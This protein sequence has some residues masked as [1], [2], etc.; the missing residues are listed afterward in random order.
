MTSPITKLPLIVLMLCGSTAW[1][2]MVSGNI[3]TTDGSE[4]DVQGA[5]DSARNGAI[6]KIQ[7]GSYTWN[8]PV[9]NSKNTAVHIMAQSLGGVTI[10]RGY[11]SGHLL[12]LNAS[13]NGNVE[14]SGIHFTSDLDGSNDNYTFTL[15]VNQ[16]SGQPVLIH[17]CSF[18]TGYEYAVVFHGNGGVV[19]NCSFATHSD[20]LGGI[21][22]VDTSATCAAW[23]RPDTLGG[24]A[25]KYGTGDPA[26]TLNTYIESCYFRDAANTMANWDDNSRVVWRYN[27][28]YN[29]ACG[30][31]GQETSTWGTRHW[32]VYGCTFTRSASGKAFGGTAYPLNLNYWFEIRGGTGVVTNNKLD[33]IP[34]KVGVQ[35][36]VFSINRLGQIPC[37]TGYP[38]AH[39]TGQGWSASSKA[40]F[41]TPRVSQDG[42]GA[43]SDPLYV[44]NNT[45]SLT[46]SPNYVLPSQY[47]PDECAKGQKIETFLQR[48]RDYFVNVAM[49]Q[50]TPFTYPHPLRKKTL[51]PTGS[52]PLQVQ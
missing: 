33:E 43:V 42:V 44:W 34:T 28:M 29:A 25:T 22:F 19:W 41:G 35:L 27:E 50:W 4:K 49:P 3:Y 51:G 17:D 2:S 24:S 48:N 23:N 11:K 8:R 39:Q 12:V 9:T 26:G 37:Q 20:A 15:L 47:S 7:N 31:H 38:A 13:P 16:L 52:G 14:L 40:V 18:V 32:E 1:C 10:K 45:G 46:T 36:N 5:L 6:I 30:S 21:S